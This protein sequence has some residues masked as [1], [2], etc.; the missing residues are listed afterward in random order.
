ML[1]SYD[2][3]LI[4]RKA[5][6]LLLCGTALVLPLL[7]E[8]LTSASAQDMNPGGEAAD[9]ARENDTLRQN[10]VIVTAQKRDEDISD[11]PM[12]VVAASGERL[13]ELGI[14]QVADLEKIVPGF[15]YQ[16]SYFGTPVYTLRGVGF[17]N[18]S[19]AAPP[20][21]SVYMDQAPIPYPTQ[22]R[23]VGLDIS[24]VE[25][26][27]GPQGTLFGQNSTGGAVNYVVNRPTTSPEGEVEL[28]VGNYEAYSLETV[29]SGPLTDTLSGRVAVK[30]E[31]RDDWQRSPTHN[32]ALGQRDFLTGRILLDWSPSS[33]VDFKFSYNGW[34]DRSDTQA[35]Q[36]VKTVLQNPS[37]YQ[38]LIPYLLSYENHPLDAEIADWNPERSYERDDSFEQLGMRVDWAFSDI[39]TLTSISTYS[40]YSQNAPIDGDGTD[41]LDFS[42]ILNANIESISQELRLA[43]SSNDDRFNWMIGASYSKD[44]SLELGFLE[45]DSTLGGAGDV[46]FYRTSVEVNGQEVDTKA[47][48]AGIDYYLTESVRL[49][50]SARYT[51]S[52]TD[53]EGCW[54]DSGDGRLA[55]Y[56]GPAFGADIPAGGCVTI[57]SNTFQI[58]DIAQ[59]QLHEDNTSWRIGAD[60][61]PQESLLLY[62]N[63]TQGYKAG[64]FSTLPFVFTDQITPVPQESVVAYELGFKWSSANGTLNTNGALFHYD[65]SDKQLLATVNTIL[66]PLPSLNTIPDSRVSGAELSVVWSPISGLLLSASGT[67]SDSEVSGATMVTDPTGTLINIDGEPFPVTPELQLSTDIEYEF[68][69]NPELAGYVGVTPRYRSDSNATF[70]GGPDFQMDGYTLVDLRVGITTAASDWRLELWGRNVTDEAYVTNVTHFADTDVRMLGMPRTYGIRIQRNF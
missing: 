50:A 28:S 20:A 36:H 23:G 19:A 17:Q 61:R 2:P 59:E 8:N 67:Y 33:D 30:M 32:G 3:E 52:E 12:S 4:G 34:R 18:P 60:W 58:P 63:I 38:L 70:G 9:S 7:A 31:Q 39:A 35:F 45:S 57:D 42:G 15:S 44:D 6:G 47:V 13:D 54:R 46:K 37:G 48:F 1:K 41:V 55:G 68:D 14:S 25:V 65:Y 27:K 53:F 5:R 51:Q 21:V 56:F 43:G 22:A 10:T 49:Q 24:R 26:L 29:L 66:G 64:G 40:N 69:I 11:V 16:P 62:G